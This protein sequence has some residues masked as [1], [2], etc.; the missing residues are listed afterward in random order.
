MTIIS[1]FSKIHY[2]EPIKTFPSLIFL[3]FTFTFHKIEQSGNRFVE[4]DEEFCK[5]LL[6][7][8][9]QKSSRKKKHEKSIFLWKKIGAI[10]QILGYEKP[11]RCGQNSQE[12]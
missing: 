11:S 8:E 3:Q 9:R 5:N 10:P 4:I 2:F 12:P 1:A 6:N 7:A